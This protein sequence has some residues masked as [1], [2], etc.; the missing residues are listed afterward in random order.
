[1]IKNFLK[2]KSLHIIVGIK[3]LVIMMF[4]L[5]VSIIFYGV[6][7]I[8]KY[9]YIFLIT[10]LITFIVIEIILFFI[11]FVKTY[12]KKRIFHILSAILALVITMIIWGPY[13]F[14]PNG[15]WLDYYVVD[16]L[17]TLIPFIFFFIFTYLAFF[18]VMDVIIAF[19]FLIRE[20][21]NSNENVIKDNEEKNDIRVKKI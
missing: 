10:F 12:L 14:D 19:V 16:G 3:T 13:M 17:L 15:L 7:S 8:M 5:A 9:I 1:M 20:K 4:I 2:K 11:Y 6:K 18:L 21:K